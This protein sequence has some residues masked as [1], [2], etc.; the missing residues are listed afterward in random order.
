MRRGRFAPS[1]TGLLHLGNVRSALLG[2]L[3]ARSVGGEFWLRIEDLDPERAKPQ[4]TEAIFRDL[5]YL[6]LTWDGPVWRQ[7]ERGRVYEAAL[8]QLRRANRVYPCVCSRAEIAR[9]A[10]APHA[11]EDGP[12]YPGTCASQEAPAG[13]PFSLRFRAAPGDEA[14]FDAVHGA[15]SQDVQH[16]VG[17]FVVRRVDGVASY[18]LAVVVDDAAAGITDVLRADD[19]LMSTPRQLQLLRALGLTPPKYAHVPLLLQADGRRL[20]KREGAT[21]VAGLRERGVSAEAIIGL[22]AK[23][24]GLSDGSPQAAAELIAD[25]SLKKMSHAPTVVMDAELEQLRARVVM[26]VVAAPRSIEPFEKLGGA[27]EPTSLEAKEPRALFMT[28]ESLLTLAKAGDS[29]AL[30]ALIDLDASEDNGAYKWLQVAADFGHDVDDAIGI[31]ENTVLHHD[32][33]QF[34]AGQAHFELGVAYLSAGEGLPR[35]LDLAGSHLAN[36]RKCRY[37]ES[38]QGGAR[39]VVKA[40]K[41]LAADALQIF[42]KH[43]KP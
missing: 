39:I 5:E 24:S 3:H 42:D 18:Q 27:N 34:I 25:F 11:G 31:L 32:D 19:L 36:A 28:T 2:W 23:W 22:L 17:D 40:R 4:F 26:P 14:F 6:G 12:V 33:N 29:D 37:P 13:K 21:T 7:S 15:T 43:Y 10:S 20:A 30:L 38:I 16:T 35:N 1:P 8:E 41:G 9:A